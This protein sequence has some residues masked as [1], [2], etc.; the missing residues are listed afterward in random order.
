M[1]NIK[2]N[3]EKIVLLFVRFALAIG[4]ISAL[5]DRFGLWGNAGESGVA[6]GNFETFEAYVAFLNPYLHSSMIPILS[7]VVTIVELV[8]AGLLILGL[9]LRAS[10]LFS[11]L[12][13][14]S[15]AI[16]M[17][18]VSGVKAP[19]DYSVFTAASAAMIL[20]LYLSSDKLSQKVEIKK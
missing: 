15:F 11:A 14:L 9:Y 4:F 13:L 18:F 2:I 5:A 20:F 8:L 10:A 17:S 16:G 3:Q 1:N 7:W 19:L 6:W 12:L